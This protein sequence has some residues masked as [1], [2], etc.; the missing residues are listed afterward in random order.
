MDLDWNPVIHTLDELSDGTHSFLELSYIV[1][2]YGRER[3]LEGLLFLADRG[4]IELS[5]GR[6]FSS[7]SVGEWP[8]RL[9][10]AFG[11]EGDPFTLAETSVD[12][13][14]KGEQVLRLLNIG[15]PP[16]SQTDE[17]G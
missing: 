9:R 5:S 16:L 10:E 15:H 12:L 4:L 13:S 7:I 17:G 8:D 6:D 11:G 1:P 2:R 3:F 14:E